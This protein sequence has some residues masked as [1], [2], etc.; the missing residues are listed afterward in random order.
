MAAFC[1]QC[2]IFA[3]LMSD[4][5]SQF[6]LY[7][8]SFLNLI[9]TNGFFWWSS[10]AGC[11]KST[12]SSKLLGNGM[13]RTSF[14]ITLSHFSKFCE[15]RQKNESMA[16][17]GREEGET[18]SPASTPM[19]IPSRKLPNSRSC[20]MAPFLYDLIFIFDVHLAP[21]LHSKQP[22]ITW[23]HFSL[24]LF[25]LSIYIQSNYRYNNIHQFSKLFFSNF[26]SS[27]GR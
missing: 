6:R 11:W 18:S 22:N 1:S 27:N 20:I 15:R 13:R 26:S 7:Q 14:P 12:D 3:Q 4:T 10:E 2:L 17:F 8:A 24:K 9:Y 25:V 16:R 21:T 5:S 23:F 19:L